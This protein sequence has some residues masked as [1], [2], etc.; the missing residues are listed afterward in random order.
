M[1]KRIKAWSAR[2]NDSRTCRLNHQS[3]DFVI[4]KR[5]NEKESRSSQNDVGDYFVWRL[6]T[7]VISR[8]DSAKLPV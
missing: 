4:G 2:A 8:S 7:H 5:K 3:P 6:C 1:S